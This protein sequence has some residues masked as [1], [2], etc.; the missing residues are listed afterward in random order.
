VLQEFLEL[1][2][3]ELIARCTSK[4]AKRFSGPIPPTEADH[5]VPVLLEQMVA[6]LSE[7]T[8]PLTAAAVGM[9]AAMHG[10]E[11]R[12]RGYSIDQVVHE[13]GDV[14]QAITELA[15]EL[16]F[17][18]HIR[19]FRALNQCLDNAI[20]DA[21]CSYGRAVQTSMQNQSDDLRTRIAGFSIEQSR[22][23][24]IA[25]SAFVAIRSGNV[26]PSGAT[27]NLL[28]HTLAELL[29]HGDSVLP[30]IVRGVSGP[31]AN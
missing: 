29:Y 18:I 4:S 5:G 9:S 17:T 11:L 21:V 3:T 6:A 31:A 1:N 13:Y 26:G 15:E 25:S 14:C 16:K 24:D 30:A 10:N 7:P 12:R 19:E 27:G 22:L 2:R 8:A 23:V 28:M 20:A